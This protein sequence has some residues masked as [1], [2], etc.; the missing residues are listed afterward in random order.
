MKNTSHLWYSEHAS[1]TKGECGPL[2]PGDL[3]LKECPNKACG[4]DLV[5]V[6]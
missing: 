3:Y 5:F 4:S 1:I 2:A 6:I